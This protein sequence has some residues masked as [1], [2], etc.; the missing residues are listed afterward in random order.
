MKK[1]VA[2]YQIIIGL[3]IIGIWIS[4]FLSNQIPETQTELIRI[5]MHILAE[6]TTGV[7]LISSGVYILTKKR[8][9]S[10][11]DVSSGSLIYTLIASPGYYAQKGEWAVFAIFLAMLIITVTMLLFKK[12]IT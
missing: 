6:I 4:L 7:L 12:K 3:G 8:L 9:S 2:I 5:T 11:F 1:V 10:L